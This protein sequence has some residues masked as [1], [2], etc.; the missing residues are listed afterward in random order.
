[1]SNESEVIA[2]L[3]TIIADLEGQVKEL[4]KAADISR[5]K[6][7]QLEVLRYK[8]A[9]NT[10][11]QRSA[12]Y[13]R[14]NASMRKMYQELEDRTNKGTKELEDLRKMHDTAI[15]INSP[16]LTYGGKLKIAIAEVNELR[17]QLA[18]A[19]KKDDTIS[20]LRSL[21]Y[22]REILVS[23]LSEQLDACHEIIDEHRDEIRTLRER[24]ENA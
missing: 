8:E 21:L 22:K 1:M 6:E 16:S 4:E 20:K 3:Q 12:R 17:K 15:K 23:E 10:L 14:E 24:L 5:L 7:L 18:E 9:Y 2:G 19:D 13:E 11:L